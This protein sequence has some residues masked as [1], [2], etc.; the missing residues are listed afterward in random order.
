[1][2]FRVEMFL[3]PFLLSKMILKLGGMMKAKLVLENGEILYGKA[4]GYLDKVIGELVFTTSMTGYQE[5]LTDPSYYGQIVVMTYPL[6]GNYGLNLNDNQ[7]NSSKVKG[8]I[9]K[10]DAKLPN[11]FRCEISLKGY[12]KENKIMGLKGLDTRYLTKIIRENGA[13][14]AIITT[15]DLLQEEIDKIF[16]DFNNKNAV[17]NVSRTEITEIKGKNKKIAVLDLG[18]KQN[19][20]DSFVKRECEVVIFPVSTR[21]EVI[22]SYNPDAI[23]LSNGPGDP[24]D[25]PEIIEMT[26]K[27]IEEKKTVIGIC[28]GHQIV[29]LSLGGEVSKMKFGHRGSNHPIKDIDKNKIFISSQNHG[30]VVTKIPSILR[31]SHI[32]LNDNTIEGMKSIDKNKHRIMTVQFHPEASPGPEETAYIFDEFISMIRG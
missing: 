9:V 5:I 1:M 17:K 13:M 22:D 18:I 28:L 3:F 4:F 12:L 25:L 16:E 29:A 31:E 20:I 23:F 21:K 14:K 11:N 15:A 32:N 24:K 26:R 7:S 30:Y 6:I 2:T 10:E 19:I 27:F 8:F